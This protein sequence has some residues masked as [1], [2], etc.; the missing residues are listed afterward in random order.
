M[1]ACRA[2]YD[3]VAHVTCRAHGPDVVG[4]LSARRGGRVG[5]SSSYFAYVMNA[6]AFPHLLENCTIWDDLF[7]YATRECRGMSEPIGRMAR[8]PSPD[9]VAAY[10]A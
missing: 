2:R 10:A 8:A 5:P 6:Q 1:E 7:A 3:P 4:T 9:V